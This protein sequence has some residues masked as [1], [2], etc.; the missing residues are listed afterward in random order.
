MGIC[1]VKVLK[2]KEAEM[3]T[4]KTVKTKSKLRVARDM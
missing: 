4:G 2:K 1:R 3:D